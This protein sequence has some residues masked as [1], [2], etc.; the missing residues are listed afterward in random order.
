MG[1]GDQDSETPVPSGHGV[2]VSEQNS[3]PSAGVLVVSPKA[4]EIRLHHTGLWQESG[5]S[6]WRPHCFWMCCE[7]PS[8]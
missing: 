4:E 8:V 2:S 6:T 3:E 5:C 7:L 1:N